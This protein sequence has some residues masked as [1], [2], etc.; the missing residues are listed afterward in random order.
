[1]NNSQFNRTVRLNQNYFTSILPEYLSTVL[2]TP[3]LQNQIDKLQTGSSRQGLN[4]EQIRKI[5]IP[6]TDPNSQLK[7]F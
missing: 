4:F 6:I 2:N 5:I 1:M 3:K 7:I